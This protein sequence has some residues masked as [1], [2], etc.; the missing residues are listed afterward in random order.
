MTQLYII[1]IK[2]LANG[3]FEH[4]VSWAFDEDANKAR[5]KGE[6]T[7][8]AKL[9]EAAISEY[10]SHAV[11]LISQEGFPIMYQ[12]YKHEAVAPTPTPEPE[13]EVEENQ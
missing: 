12:C 5:L 2:K 6:S 11:T 7:Y 8:H 4:E 3:E 9:A 13:T 10:E 1:E